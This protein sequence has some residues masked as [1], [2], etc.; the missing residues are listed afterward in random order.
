MGYTFRLTARVLLFAPSHRQ[1]STY[2]GLCHTSHGA[3]AG[4][5]NSPMGQP[6]GGSIRRPIGATSL[7]KRELDG[8]TVAADVRRLSCAAGRC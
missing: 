7:R 5:T 1:N 6:H 2:D 4:T 8:L 3:L